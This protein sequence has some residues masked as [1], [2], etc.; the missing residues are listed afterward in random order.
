ML[1]PI[2]FITNWLYIYI[3]L[4]IIPLAV[5]LVMSFFIVEPPEYLF[6]KKQYDECLASLNYI[7]RF[8]GQPEL[9][10]FQPATAVVAADTSKDLG[11][12]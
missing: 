8:N 5:L 9:K 6:Y 10:E 1:S 3:F 12:P 4:F 7:A 11:Q 2:L